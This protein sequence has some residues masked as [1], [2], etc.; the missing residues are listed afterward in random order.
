[1]KFNFK[2]YLK[3]A[4][5][6]NLSHEGF[7][8]SILVNL[9]ISETQIMLVA[10]ILIKNSYTSKILRIFYEYSSIFLE[11]VKIVIILIKS[12]YTS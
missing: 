12:M 1:M 7:G 9:R 2:K 3:K 6:K 5:L 11:F 4:A 10:T 8:M